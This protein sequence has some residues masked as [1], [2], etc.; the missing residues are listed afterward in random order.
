MAVGPSTE[1]DPAGLLAGALAGVDEAAI[2]TLAAHCEVV[3]FAPGARIASEGTSADALYVVASGR[4]QLSIHQRSAEI[5]L[6]TVAEGELVGWSWMVAPN[7]WTF[8]VSTA[9]GSVL[10]R[11]AATTIE[12]LMEADPVAGLSLARA[13]VAMVSRRLRDTR[14]Q[15]L[16]MY[17]RTSG[18]GS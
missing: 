15:L 11:V 17:A 9:T 2:A 16:D 12:A 14:V 13:M 6:A 18:E 1:V 10:V 8:D 3:E 7:R 5:P 4:V